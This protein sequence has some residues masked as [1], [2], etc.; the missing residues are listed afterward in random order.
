MEIIIIGI[1]ISL[2]IYGVYTHFKIHPSDFLLFFI[3]TINCN[4]CV[5]F[6]L[7]L[8]LTGDLFLA[9]VISLSFFIVNKFIDKYIY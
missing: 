5:S 9:S 6:W 3:S 2:Q 7:T 1:V 4:K 8:I